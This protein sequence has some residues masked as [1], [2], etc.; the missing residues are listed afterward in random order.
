[1][2]KWGNYFSQNSQITKISLGCSVTSLKKTQ[3]ILW[4]QT[5]YKKK[6]RIE[7][8][9]HTKNLSGIVMGI[10]RYFFASVQPVKWD[11]QSFAVK[12]IELVNVV[13]FMSFLQTSIKNIKNK[14]NDWLPLWV[15]PINRIVIEIRTVYTQNQY[16]FEIPDL[17]PVWCR[18]K[19]SRGCIHLEKS[20][21]MNL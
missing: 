14:L 20:K 6:I 10:S 15:I 13:A 19:N 8:F 16:S 17:N 7:L 1:M 5:K 21:W 3:I 11:L 12:P 2:A 9:K 4:N 18:N